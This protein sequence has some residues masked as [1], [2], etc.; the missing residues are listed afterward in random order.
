MLV[1]TRP[2]KVDGASTYTGSTATPM[3]P[4]TC[5]G[6]ALEPRRPTRFVRRRASVPE[7]LPSFPLPATRPAYSQI[8]IAARTV[9]S[10]RRVLPCDP[11]P[12]ASEFRRRIEQVTSGP[13]C[14]SLS[15]IGRGTLH[16]TFTFL[17]G[18]TGPVSPV[19]PGQADRPS[20]P[21][22]PLP[23]RW[24]VMI[25]LTGGASIA[26]PR[27]APD[28]SVP[29][30]TCFPGIRGSVS[31]RRSPGRAV[32]GSFGLRVMSKVWRS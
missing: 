12:M 15:R 16:G 14:R 22:Q 13:S 1:P 28:R 31:A 2:T 9:P 11:L 32:R 26:I 10:S 27:L 24:G 3:R 17:F 4:Y 29:I 21:T 6:G 23:E 30:N 18:I 5:A 25:G 7:A 8:V 20:R 19:F